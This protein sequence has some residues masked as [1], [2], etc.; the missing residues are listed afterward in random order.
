MRWSSPVWPANRWFFVLSFA[1]S[2]VLS[3]G[4]ATA[5]PT[6]LVD[7]LVDAVAG[8]GGFALAGL[9]LG[10]SSSSRISPFPSVGSAG[11]AAA[12]SLESYEN[13]VQCSA[14]HYA[15]QAELTNARFLDLSLV[16]SGGGRATAAATSAVFF[17][18]VVNTSVDTVENSSSTDINFGFAGSTALAFFGA[19]LSLVDELLELLDES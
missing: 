17:A 3:P 16:Q 14:R 15:C 12:S 10:W 18:T 8:G 1:V 19:S 5:V 11:G 4:L 13:K 9:C 2:L 7:A 6:R